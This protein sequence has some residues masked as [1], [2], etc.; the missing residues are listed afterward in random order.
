[1]ADF[2]V[3]VVNQSITKVNSLNVPDYFKSYRVG[4]ITMNL[5]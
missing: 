1:M 3:T 5:S 2:Y 4:E